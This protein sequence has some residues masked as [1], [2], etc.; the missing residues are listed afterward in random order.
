[1]IFQHIIIKLT[2]FIL[3]LLLIP[4]K[5]T[6]NV[7]QMLTT[8]P[9]SSKL[10]EIPPYYL[11]IPPTSH[12]HLYFLC[13]NLDQVCHLATLPDRSSRPPLQWT[14]RSRWKSSAMM[15]VVQTSQSKSVPVMRMLISPVL[16]VS[17]P[18]WPYL[19]W[20]ISELAKL[21]SCLELL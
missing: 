4:L 19:A 7:M 8:N 16:L 21:N 13:Q 2:K 15:P 14:K 5:T 18:K 20:E 9:H 10:M 11:T 3:I 1:M 6:T 17:M 12:P